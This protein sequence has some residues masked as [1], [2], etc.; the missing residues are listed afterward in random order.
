M[1]PQG[2]QQPQLQGQQ[3]G[4][5]Q[6]Q[7]QGQ[8]QPQ[9]QGQRQPQ[10]QGQQQP[11]QQGQQQPEF[12]VPIPPVAAP[13]GKPQ[14]VV[15]TPDVPLDIVMDRHLD[16]AAAAGQDVVV[17]VGAGWCAPCRAFHDAL[18]AGKMD[19][20]LPGVRFVEF[21]ADQDTERLRSYG[22]RWQYVPL[23]ARP[24]R[25]G[26]STGQQFA[27][28]PKTV[29]DDPLPHLAEKIASLLGR[30]PPR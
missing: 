13:K 28:V 14:L 10:Q 19:A 7:Q 12:A 6:P 8:Q 25:G 20:L 22:Y 1:Q 23:F 15:A 11:Q 17:Y 30:R 5:Q 29:L 18:A 21:D 16:E 3:Q 9:Q 26:R 24:G 4:Q 2:Q 27:G